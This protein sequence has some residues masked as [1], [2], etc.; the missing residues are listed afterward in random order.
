MSDDV[1]PAQ[2][3]RRVDGSDGADDVPDAS[4]DRA[5]DATGTHEAA[6][7]SESSGRIGSR[8]GLQDALMSTE[9]DVPLSRV[10]APWDPEAGGITRVYRGLRKM[11]N[12]SGTPAVVD[13]VVGAAEFVK[14]FEPDTGEPDDDGGGQEA[15]NSE[16]DVPDL[17]E[18][19]DSGEEAVV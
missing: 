9:P 3:V 15:D 13:V 17:A 2:A 1:T 6:E 5:A 12:W 16:R 11:L 4:S 10:D 7:G 14:D 18:V 8:Q 19:G